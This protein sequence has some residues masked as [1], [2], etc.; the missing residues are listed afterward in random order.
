MFL[1]TFGKVYTASGAL[2]L[3]GE[4]YYY[5][6]FFNKIP[7]YSLDNTT[8][9]TKT[10]TVNPLVGNL[11]F[12]KKN[13]L[14]PLSK[15]PKCIKVYPFTGALM[16]AVGVSN[17]GLKNI[18]ARGIWQ[19]REEPFIISIIPVRN[20]YQ[21]RLNELSEVARL[22]NNYEF[23]TKIGLQ[24]NVSCPNTGIMDDY[25]REVE[26][27][28]KLFRSL[29]KVPI[30]LKVNVLFPIDKAVSL[31][32]LCDIIT[33]SNTIPYGSFPD[34]IYW[35]KFKGLEKF[36]GGGLSGS[37]IFPLVKQW[38][39][40]FRIL[41][42]KTKIKACGGI[43]RAKDVDELKLAG[44]NAIEIGSVKLLRPWRVKSIVEKGLSLDC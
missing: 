23:K 34:I 40:N 16:N 44:A 14:T 21:K 33:C 10:V 1:K 12:S 28:L 11:P 17:P 15:W 4:G 41:D 38:I 2:G 35:K 7:G 6:K 24:L 20:N 31:A 19:K 18:L 42:K 22:I 3:D 39:T 29:L 26:T 43:M 30:D 25:F 13:S 9:I 27:Y 36:G 8:F 37:P 5:D 32:P